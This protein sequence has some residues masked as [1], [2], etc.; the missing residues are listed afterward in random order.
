[1]H[2]EESGVLDIRA[3]KRELARAL[4]E[5]LVTPDDADQVIHVGHAPLPDYRKIIADILPS[6]NTPTHIDYRKTAVYNAGMDK[7]VLARNLRRLRRAERLTQIE[8][9]KLASVDDSYISKLETERVK[10]PSYEYL[11]RLAR[12]LR[13]SV[14]ELLGVG[15]AYN[16]GSETDPSI[17]SPEPAPETDALQQIAQ[18]IDRLERLIVH[19][20]AQA[21]RHDVSEPQEHMVAAAQPAM[22]TEIGGFDTWPR[23][24]FT[25]TV[26][27][28]CLEPEIMP[29]DLLVCDR[30][31][32]PAPGDVVVVE[33]NGER[34]MKRVVRRNGQLHLTSKRGPLALPSDGAS[35]LGV[36]IEVY[37]R[38]RTS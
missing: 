5:I 28:D 32:P 20:A 38:K 1:M 24:Q 9:G 29:G 6:V 15:G 22:G 18:K 35:V 3:A 4:I 25:V 26:E 34:H 14:T 27:G 13:V 31:R 8:L 17:S 12:A 21:F 37:E 33:V 23:R 10:D 30:D 11:D 19:E 16:V 2:T 7:S 36:M